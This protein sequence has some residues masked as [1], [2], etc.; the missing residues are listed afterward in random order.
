MHTD[1]DVAWLRMPSWLCRHVGWLPT[2]CTSSRA[3]APLWVDTAARAAS[4]AAAEAPMR[5]SS[6][7]SA[8]SRSFWLLLSYSCAWGRGQW[9]ST[10]HPA[11][12][13]G[14]ARTHHCAQGVQV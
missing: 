12:H 4:T 11:L 6:A 9:C 2:R 7:S 3:P 14:H 8:R 1:C 10:W 13:A 5:S